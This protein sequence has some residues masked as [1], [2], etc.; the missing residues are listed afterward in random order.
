MKTDSEEWF[1]GVEIVLLLGIWALRAMPFFDW[2]VG[3]IGR[4]GG[5]VEIISIRYM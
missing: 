1:W 4:L 5:I 2:G 3:E